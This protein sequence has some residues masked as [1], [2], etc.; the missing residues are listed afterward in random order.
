MNDEFDKITTLE[1]LWDWCTNNRKSAWRFPP[2]W[3]IRGY[4]GSLPLGIVADIPAP[5]SQKHLIHG[6]PHAN[7]IE[8]FTTYYDRRLYRLMLE[9]GLENAHLMDTRISIVNDDD[10]DKRV[11]LKQI[12][13]LRLEALLIMGGKNSKVWKTVQGYLK[14]WHGA[15]PGMYKIWHYT[16]RYATAEKWEKV[17]RSALVE[18]AAD[19]PNLAG[20]IRLQ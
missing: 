19:H 15:L 20:F 9:Y 4:L 1:K 16:Y 2:K 11:F 5:R 3:G 14:D 6:L 8:V 18:V 12:E 10:Q 7:D 17:F 13:L